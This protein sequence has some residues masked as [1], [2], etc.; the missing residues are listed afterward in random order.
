MRLFL[1]INLSDPMKDALTEAQ[2]ALRRQ[3][4]RGKETTRENL[5]LTL[6]FIGEY[7]DPDGVMDVVEAVPFHPFSLKLEGFIGRGPR[8][9]GS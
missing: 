6:A 5:H 2:A 1:A 8:P 7:N 3:G 9:A 4:V